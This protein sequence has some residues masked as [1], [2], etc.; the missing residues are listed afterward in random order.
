MLVPNRK[1]SG[2]GKI[3]ASYTAKF[4]LEVVRFA[5]ENGNRA[6]GKKFDVNEVNVRRWIEAK[7]A[8]E[9]TSK[10]RQSFRGKKAKYP[11]LETELMG[12]VRK[13]ISSI[14]RTPIFESII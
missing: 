11:E 7:D 9:K 12:Y 5:Q 4:K 14:V 6:A 1:C 3:R 2:M 8:L 10:N 13:I